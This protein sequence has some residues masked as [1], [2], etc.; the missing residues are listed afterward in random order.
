[1]AAMLADPDLRALAALD[2]LDPEDFVLQQL[3]AGAA[4]GSCAAPGTHRTLQSLSPAHA[5]TFSSCVQAASLAYPTARSSQ[6]VDDIGN[7]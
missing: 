2:G 7:L 3:A 1:M 6:E 5:H 4:H